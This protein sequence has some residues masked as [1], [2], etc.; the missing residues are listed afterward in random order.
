MNSRPLVRWASCNVSQFESSLFLSQHINFAGVKSGL[1]SCYKSTP[2]VQTEQY[3]PAGHCLLCQAPGA[4]SFQQDFQQRDF[5][6]FSYE[7]LFA[8][9]M[10]CTCAPVWELVQ[11]L[12]CIKQTCLVCEAL[13]TKISCSVTSAPTILALTFFQKVRVDFATFSAISIFVTCL[14]Y[15]SPSLDSTIF[16][17]NILRR[18]HLLVGRSPLGRSSGLP[19]SS[20][21]LVVRASRTRHLSFMQSKSWTSSH[22]G[23]EVQNIT[24]ANRYS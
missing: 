21:I 3:W 13:T 19:T 7:H 18:M 9:I 8:L 23:A 16:S 2:H 5:Q 24:N 20:V 6:N 22:T 15:L 12:L 17:S 11:L 10:F 1:R 14:M 4:G